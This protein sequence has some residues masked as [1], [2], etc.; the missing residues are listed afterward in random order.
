MT[1]NRIS[2][3]VPTRDR[4]ELLRKTLACA[5]AQSWQDKEIVVVDEASTDGTVAYVGEQYPWVR[6]VALPENVG[7]AAGNNAGARA[8]QGRYLAFLNNDTAACPGW[9]RALRSGVDEGS[10]FTLTTSRIVYMHDPEVIDSAGPGSAASAFPDGEAI[11]SGTLSVTVEPTPST[12][13]VSS[14][15]LRCTA[16]ARHTASPGSCVVSAEETGR[17]SRSRT[18]RGMPQPESMTA[19]AITGRAV[20]PP[21]HRTAS[22]TAPRWVN[23]MALLTRWTSTRA[24]RSRSARP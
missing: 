23:R 13:M 21:A 7:F 6:I 4:M 11:A 15:P 12:L 2:I 10:R 19:K 18:S 16:I 22:C 3:V 8:A 17:A 14:L 5:C 20:V 24:I 1:G 9:L